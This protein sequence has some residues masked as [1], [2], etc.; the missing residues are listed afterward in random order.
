MIYVW[1]PVTV[2]WIGCV[3]APEV[4]RTAPHLLS[5]HGEAKHEEKTEDEDVFELGER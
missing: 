4:E 1:R 2:Y 5:E 3:A